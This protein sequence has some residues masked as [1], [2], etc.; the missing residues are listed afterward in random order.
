VIRVSAAVM[1]HPSRAAQVEALLGALDR[2]VP[3]VWDQRQ[4]RWDTGRRS[5][6]ASHHLVV[7]DDAVVPRDLL[8]GLEAALVYVPPEAAVSLYLG[9]VRPFASTVTKAVQKAGTAVSWIVMRDLFWGVGVVLPTGIIERLVA[10]QDRATSI[11]EYD[12]RISRWLVGM[13]VPVWYSWPSMV[14][15]ADGESLVDHGRGRHAHQAVGPD[16]SVFDHAWD[17]GSLLLPDRR[18]MPL[19]QRVSRRPVVE[20]RNPV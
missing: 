10:T 17:R 9:R 2:P 3:V 8:A 5:L 19:P 12:R 11:L 20:R 15:H 7:Q 13:N 16:R 4:D 1:A 6:L 18:S 14:D